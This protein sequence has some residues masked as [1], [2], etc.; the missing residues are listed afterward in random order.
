LVSAASPKRTLIEF[1]PAKHPPSLQLRRGRR[2]LTRNRLEKS[3][4]V[5][6]VIRGRKCDDKNRNI[7]SLAKW[8]KGAI[9]R[10][11]SGVKNSRVIE[12]HNT[13]HYVFIVDERFT[14]RGGRWAFEKC[15]SSC[16]KTERACHCG[17][18]LSHR[19]RM[20]LT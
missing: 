19:S 13:C 16:L 7:N 10:F 12:L 18:R 11:R 14:R 5:I 9:E 8:I 4:G 15:A 2:E 3:F 17:G 6:R 1:E 20:E